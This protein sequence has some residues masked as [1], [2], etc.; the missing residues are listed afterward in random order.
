MPR[1]QKRKSNL[2]YYDDVEQGSPE[3]LQLREYKFTGS[4]AYKLLTSFGAGSWAMGGLSNFKGNFHTR[5]GHL[6]EKEALELYEQINNV[7]CSTTGFVTN[8]KYPD[9]LYSPDAYLEDRV[10]EVKCFSVKEHIKAIENPS[11]KIKAQCYFGQ[12]IM[13]RPLT[14]L[15]LYNPSNEVPVEKKLVIITIKRDNDIHNNFKSI[16]RNY[17]ENRRSQQGNR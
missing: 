1:S 6:L 4:N 5:R 16:I 11:V 17:N 13:E 10:I 7:K 2:T 14:D 3:W 15:V 8:S 9:C 12:I